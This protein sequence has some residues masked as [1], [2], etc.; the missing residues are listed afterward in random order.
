[1]PYY[2]QPNK[3]P[4]NW[5]EKFY[6]WRDRAHAQVGWDFDQDASSY[7]FYAKPLREYILANGTLNN[8]TSIHC[9]QS[10]DRL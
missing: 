3:Q 9:P 7:E 1:M 2:L 8:I 4:P 5:L 6:E 10:T